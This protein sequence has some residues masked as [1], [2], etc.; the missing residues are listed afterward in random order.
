M[1]GH[2]DRMKRSATT[3]LAALLI[4]PGAAALAGCE[5]DDAAKKDLEDAGQKLDK[6]LGN[7]DEKVG[8]A[9]EDAVDKVDD[10]DGK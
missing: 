3:L 7:N 1:I 6:E 9:G 8:K 2:T 4:V 10:N 5:S